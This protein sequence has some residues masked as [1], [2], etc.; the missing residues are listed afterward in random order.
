MAYPDSPERFKRSLGL[1]QPGLVIAGDITFA[2]EGS[3]GSNC[4]GYQQAT[5]REKF[6][7][8]SFCLAKNQGEGTDIT[9]IFDVNSYETVNS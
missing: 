3:Q 5:L 1:D 4:P 2:L 6:T 9:L 8:R 7:I